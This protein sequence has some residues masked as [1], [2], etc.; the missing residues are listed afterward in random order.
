LTPARKIGA[1]LAAGCPLILKAAEETPA[2][3]MALVRAFAE[4]GLPAG[5]LQLVFGEPAFISERLIQ[6][7]AIRKVSF[8]GSVAVGKSL[9]R[10]ASDG[11]KRTTM[12]LGGHA[13]AIV[14]DDV[15]PV[16]AGQILAASKFRNAGQVCISPSRFYVQDAAFDSFLASFLATTKALVVGRGIDSGVTMGPLAHERRPQAMEA[17]I[18]DAVE[19]GGRVRTGG[20]RIRNAG[21][22]FAPTVVT[23]MP[24]DSRLMIEEP[25]GPI[26]P[27][28]R[29]RAVNEVMERANSLPLGLASYAFTSNNARAM[30]VAEGLRAGMVG[31]N[32]LAVSTPETPFGG[33]GESGLGQEGGVE[34][35]AAYLDV[36]FVAQA[37]E[38][39]QR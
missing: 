4:S 33:V 19:R 30:A 34:G 13:P 31:V 12:E 18:A 5:V 37:A 6:A 29:F 27:I 23:D 2:T 38:L 8:T 16:R 21:Y 28:T 15:D 39:Q 11:V 26:A 22:F 10:L 20:R 35:L 36:K 17:F 24:D 14:F 1:A 9:L 7:D 3:A 32:T 25:F